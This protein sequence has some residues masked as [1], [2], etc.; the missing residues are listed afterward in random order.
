MG[1]RA[2]AAPPTP[3]PTAVA[4]AQTAS[5]IQT[6]QANAALNRVN[7]ITPQ[8]SLTYTPPAS[9]NIN[10]P[11]T[12][13][14]TYSPTEQSLYNL[15]TQGQQLYGATALS[16][17]GA[18]SG[19]LSTPINTN[20]GDVRQ[21]YIN[22][23]MALIQPDL[24][25]QRQD[26]ES[27]LANQ[28]IAQGSTAYTNAMRDFSNSQ[29]ATYNN[30]LGSAGNTVGQAIQQQIALRD[31][32]VNEATALL[33]GQMVQGPN[34]T[35]VPQ[36]QVDPTNV[37]GAYGLQQQAYQNQLAAY[38]AQTQAMGGM[39]GGLGSIGGMLGAAA[40]M[41]PQTSD[42]R[43]KTDIRKVGELNLPGGT[44]PIKSFRYHGSPT[45]N[46]GLIAQDLEPVLP[47]AVQTNPA[48]GLKSINYAQALMAAHGAPGSK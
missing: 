43:L 4:A 21:Q 23:Q 45:R 14:Q 36:T 41:Q 44:V 46:L 7:Q 1:K 39:M 29:A 15:S 37:L 5:N 6:A 48:T 3:D 31:Q 17:L 47:Q 12:A 11:W 25:V 19:A 13:T 2:P 9:G 27:K 28:G 33:T 16:Q 34:F 8:G 22:S 38:Q 40:I 35:N 20:Y 18:A 42:E 24:D 30:I 26:L 32:P 10:D